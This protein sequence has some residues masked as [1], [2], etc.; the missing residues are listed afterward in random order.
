MAVSDVTLAELESL[1]VVDSVDGQVALV[2]AEQLDNPRAGMAV[3][4][5]ARELRTVMQAIRDGR[6]AV[7]GDP[8][9]DLNA[10][11]A[12]RGAASSAG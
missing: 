4:G 5:D 10:R 1:G 2:L 8:I 9:V 11:R 12:A 3:S 6:P 7:K